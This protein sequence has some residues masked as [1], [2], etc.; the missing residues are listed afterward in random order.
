VLTSREWAERW[1]TKKFLSA[2]QTRG[3][4]NTVRPRDVVGKTRRWLASEL[5][6]EL[7]TIDKKIKIANQELTELVASAGSMRVKP[8]MMT[9]T[10]ACVPIWRPDGHAR[11]DIST[12]SPAAWRRPAEG[13][14][15]EREWRSASP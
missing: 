12:L 5:N 7:V 9:T 8:R 14:P 6:H 11:P 2:Q 4:L 13:L 10:R 1:R 3:L 15:V